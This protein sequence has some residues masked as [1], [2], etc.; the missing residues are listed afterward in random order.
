MKRLGFG[1]VVVFGLI[2]ATTPP[3]FGADTQAPV[4]VDWKLTDEKA[5]ISTGDATVGVEFSISDDSEIDG[6]VILILSSQSSTQS[7]GLLFS[8]LISKV[9][10]IIMMWIFKL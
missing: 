2:F 9:G 5:D 3:A 10:K 8:K 7:T 6:W 4:L 1:L